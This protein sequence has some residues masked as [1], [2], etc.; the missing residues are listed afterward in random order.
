MAFLERARSVVSH[1]RYEG[2]HACIGPRVTQEIIAGIDRRQT[3]RQIA[4]RLTAIEGVGAK[5]DEIEDLLMK[6]QVLSDIV[7]VDRLNEIVTAASQKTASIQNVL[8]LLRGVQTEFD[9]HRV[10]AME[11]GITALGFSRVIVSNVLPDKNVR[12]T[13]WTKK[14][15]RIE[16]LQVEDL[17]LPTNDRSITLPGNGN[18]FTF[19]REDDRPIHQEDIDLLASLINAGV[20]TKHRIKSERQVRNE[21]ISHR[22]RELISR[23]ASNIEDLMKI[24]LIS[25]TS[26]F[27]I[28]LAAIFMRQPHT[29]KFSGVFG[30]GSL[31]EEE[32][33]AAL[34]KLAGV[35]TE[36][37]VL[38]VV[39]AQRNLDQGLNQLIREICFVGQVE[40]TVVGRDGR[41]YND[42]DKEFETPPAVA[43][44][45][46][47]AIAM[48]TKHFVVVPIRAGK[49]TNGFL[50][51]A[52]PWSGR[53]IDLEG[54]Q[55][56]SRDFV[57]LFR[58]MRRQSN[59]PAFAGKLPLNRD[60]LLGVLR[61][62]FKGVSDPRDAAREM[63][64]LLKVE[65]R[66][67]SSEEELKE[68]IATWREWLGMP[69]N[70]I[71]LD[72]A[73]DL[74]PLFGKEWIGAV[75]GA[76]IIEALQTMRVGSSENGGLCFGPQDWIRIKIEGNSIIFETTEIGIGRGMGIEML[77]L[78]DAD[79][80]DQGM[81]G[82][83]PWADETTLRVRLQNLENK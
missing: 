10:I 72:P 32:H 75:I 18:L 71:N 24:L 36:E 5:A 70:L 47:E 61:R 81:G 74:T 1:L 9:V 17:E 27:Q 45:L 63:L 16:E 19:I 54:I 49:R 56:L 34:K 30:L 50:L 55:A 48:P 23:R 57:D 3:P 46:L 58:G 33:H 79:L 14:D 37:D 20:E 12:P 67:A 51:L 53:D 68:I 25:V 42:K 40:E 78:L 22:T 66:A 11:G 73:S 69:E 52:N 35:R 39:R 76:G 64:E 65:D 44:Y 83:R 29:R 31:T 80:K 60:Q 15:D 21:N 4:E 6:H 77:K 41:F 2:P 26:N 82:L 62:A 8:N 7:S 43:E 28:N 59:A 13:Q 38:E